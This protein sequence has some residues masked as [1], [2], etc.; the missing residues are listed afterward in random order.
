MIKLRK[1][2][3]LTLCGLMKKLEDFKLGPLDLQLE[4]G[5]IT[6]FIGPNGAGK[7]TTMKCIANIYYP[8][9]GSIS[10]AGHEVGLKETAWKKQL[11]YLGD[12][13]TFLEN[14]TVEKNLETWAGFYGPDYLPLATELARRLDLPMR[15][16]PGKLS[17]GNRQK[18]GLVRALAHLPAVLVLDEPLVHLDPLAR[19]EA[20]QVLR[21]YLVDTG[22]AVF[23][24]T[25]VLNEMNGLADRLVFIMNGK[26]ISDELAVDLQSAW[27]RTLLN[28]SS[29]DGALPGELTRRSSGEDVEIISTDRAGV[30]SYLRQRAVTPRAMQRLSLEEIG[31][32]ILREGRNA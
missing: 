15:K 20:K 28:T 27:V 4:P 10:I 31:T 6:G 30:E 13:S 12:Y 1:D 32:I 24:S 17:S 22:A 25:H 7:T 3:D 11:G 16:Q 26:L 5:Q 29:T 14:W 21:E 18:L 9:A 19:D 23:I 2:A 8:D